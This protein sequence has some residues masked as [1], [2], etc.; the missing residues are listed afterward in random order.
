MKW[1]PIKSTIS[2]Q[3]AA[4]LPPPADRQL[5]VLLTQHEWHLL[6]MTSQLQIIKSQLCSESAL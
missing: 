1:S 3:R 5:S 2:Q 6:Q 4:I